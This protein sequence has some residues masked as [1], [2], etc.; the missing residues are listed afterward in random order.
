MP[1]EVPPYVDLGRNQISTAEKET[2]GAIETWVAIVA[3]E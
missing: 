1:L 2:G 3:L